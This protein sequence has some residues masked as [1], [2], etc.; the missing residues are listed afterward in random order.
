MDRTLNAREAA[1]GLMLKRLVEQFIFTKRGTTSLDLALSRIH[2]NERPAYKEAFEALIAYVMVAEQSGEYFVTQHGA[3]FLEFAVPTME[4]RQLPLTDDERI[5]ILSFLRSAVS[6]DSRFDFGQ[7]SL[8]QSSGKP[9]QQGSENGN[10]MQF[11]IGAAIISFVVIWG[12][13]AIFKH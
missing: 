5:K 4:R 9:A 1:A 12:L 7:S 13:V 3:L 6:S 10:P 8:T 11:W 2:P